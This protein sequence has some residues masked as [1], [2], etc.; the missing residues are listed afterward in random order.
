M[1][2]FRRVSEIRRKTGSPRGVAQ[3]A[4]LYV[5]EIPG[6]KPAD[7]FEDVPAN[8]EARSGYGL[9]LEN[10][11]RLGVQSGI[12]PK[13]G[14]RKSPPEIVRVQHLIPNRWE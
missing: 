5:H 2:D 8:H 12:A 14:I 10:S 13:A 9:D 4:I 11:G 7:S 3:V 6:A 1:D